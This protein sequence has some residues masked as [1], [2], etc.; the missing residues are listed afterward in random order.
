M[1]NI[2][3]MTT[4][5]VSLSALSLA[6]LSRTK[7]GKLR[8]KQR[9]A[10]LIQPCTETLKINAIVQIRIVI[11]I[12]I[13]TTVPMSFTALSLAVPPRTKEGTLMI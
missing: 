9:M 11:N 5:L 3:F 10:I 13:M 6:V 2:V 4:V 1:N 7:E 8:N 12:D